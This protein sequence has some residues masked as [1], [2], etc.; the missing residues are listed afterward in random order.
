MQVPPRVRR[1]LR[2]AVLAFATGSA[3]EIALAADSIPRRDLSKPVPLRLP[4]ADGGVARCAVSAWDGEALLSDCGTSAWRTMSAGEALL[5]LKSIV[6][7]GDASAVED[8]LAVVLSHPEPGRAA[9]AAIQ[10][11]RRSGLDP[12]AVESARGKA[13]ALRKAREA[14]EARERAARL[15]AASPEAAAFPATPWSAPART[16]FDTSSAALVEH[17]RGLLAKAGASGTLHESAAIALL[18]EGDGD[19]AR[20]LAAFLE[21][22][23]ADWIG[24]FE[25]AGV[26]VSPQARIVVVAP[27]DRDRWRL[28]VAGAFGGDPERMGAGL[29]IYPAIVAG[30]DPLAV[31]LLEP[32][33]DASRRRWSAAVGVARA[34]AHYAGSPARGPAWLNEGLPRAMADLAVPEAR[35]DLALRREGLAWIRAGGGFDALLAAGYADP[36]W[37]DR[38]AL[39]Q[40][41]SYMFVRW[42]VERS[43]DRVLAFADTLAA[44]GAA[45]ASPAPWER[46]FARAF[47]ASPAALASE[48]RAWFTVND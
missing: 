6:P 44:A 27:A 39:A 4:Q 48:A 12:A 8:A 23:A 20:T 16:A 24:R 40:S 1:F 10:W 34:I 30:G 46:R 7:A 22:F 31:V 11:G 18:A 45:Q 41:L 9:A 35:M 47:G 26:D 15:A 21:R 38:P 43:P 3:G 36:P 19:A 17:A 5:A 32:E 33:A 13:E 25:R 29:A 42:L 28:L 2:A 37:S 14:R